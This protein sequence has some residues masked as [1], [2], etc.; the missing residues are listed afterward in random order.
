MGGSNI[1]EQRGTGG[2]IMRIPR[3]IELTAAAARN[4]ISN[5][6]TTPVA[7]TL[8]HNQKGDH[9]I[10]AEIPK[11]VSFDLPEGRYRARISNLRLFNKQT[12]RGPQDWLRILFEVDVPGLSEKV[13]TLAGRSFK[14][15][16]NAG[17]ELRHF[18]TF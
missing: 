5:K 8:R 18:L 9:M 12:G 1:W 14:M 2:G 4:D 13:N 11:D 17:S 7:A 15:D 3:P 6:L 16:L 10:V